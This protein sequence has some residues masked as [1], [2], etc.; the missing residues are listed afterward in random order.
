MPNPRV[1]TGKATAPPPS[2][3]AP[4]MKDPT[5]MVSDMNQYS[6]NRCQRSPCSISTAHAPQTTAM[7]SRCGTKDPRGAVEGAPMVMVVSVMGG[8]TQSEWSSCAGFRPT[9]L[10][11]SGLRYVP[12]KWPALRALSV[13]RLFFPCPLSHG[14]AHHLLEASIGRE[15]LDAFSELGCQGCAGRLLGK[16]DK[17]LVRHDWRLQRH[18]L[19]VEVQARRLRLTGIIAGND[20]VDVAGKERLEGL[21]DAVGADDFEFVFHESVELYAVALAFVRGALLAD[22]VGLTFVLE[23]H[24]LDDEDIHRVISET[25]LHVVKVLGA[26][27]VVIDAENHV[28]VAVTRGC[29]GIGPASHVPRF[30]GHIQVRCDGFDQGRGRAA[31]AIAVLERHRRILGVTGRNDLGAIVCGH[32][33]MRGQSQ[34]HRAGPGNLHRTISGVS[35]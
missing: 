24:V 6:G 17:H 11:A 9:G 30:K 3:V 14:I 16:G 34:G 28:G 10:H 25:R 27:V 32:R 19:V 2:L 18:N 22:K 20:V 5:A 23:G 29:L 15:L 13:L 31:Y 26:L 33:G 35:A 8:I 4:A 12:G 7:I 1:M 21:V